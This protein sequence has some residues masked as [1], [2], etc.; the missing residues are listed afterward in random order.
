[1]FDIPEEMIKMMDII[2]PYMKKQGGGLLDDAPDEIKQIYQT[3]RDMF[4]SVMGG[5]M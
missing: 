2:T 1:M 3:F 5:V 4:N